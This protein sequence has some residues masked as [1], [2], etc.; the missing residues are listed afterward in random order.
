MPMALLTTSELELLRAAHIY[1]YWILGRKRTA[2]QA[3]REMR[4]MID[5]YNLSAD[6]IERRPSYK[7]L[8]AEL[9]VAA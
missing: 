7:R 6:A 1:A 5:E 9:G 3:A 4:E 2:R 8:F